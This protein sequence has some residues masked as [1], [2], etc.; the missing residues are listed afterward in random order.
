[1][2][3][4][5]SPIADAGADVELNCTTPV[6]TLDGS[7]S[8]TGANIT[9]QWTGAPNIVNA[10]TLNP[11]VTEPGIYTLIVVDANTGCSSSDEME[12]FADTNYPVISLVI[13]D[14]C[15]GSSFELCPTIVGGSGNF[16][17]EWFYNGIILANTECVTFGEF[18]TNQIGTYDVVLTDAQNG[19]SIIQSISLSATE[20][21]WPGDTDTNKVVNNFDLLNIGLA[22]D[23]TG[24]IRQNATL[25]WTAQTAENWAE[26]TPDN[27][28]YKHIDT[29]GNGTINADDTLAIIQNWGL[30]H[31]LWG[32]DDRNVGTPFYVQSDTFTADVTYA[33]PVILGA[34]D[35]P[36]AEVYG[37]AFTL[38]FD[39]SII[40]SN[41]S[42]NFETSWLGGIDTD[43]IAIQKTTLYT[44]GGRI[45]AAVTRIDGQN[46]TGFGQMGT[47]YIT[48]EDIIFQAPPG[49]DVFDVEKEL[50]FKIENVKMIGFDGQI[51]EVDTEPQPSLSTATNSLFLAHQIQVFPN[52]ATDFLNIYSPFFLMEQV[53]VFNLSGQRIYANFEKNSQL[54]LNTNSWLPST[55]FLKIK[56]Q[57]GVILKKVVIF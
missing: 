41:A 6:A 13:P 38:V 8:A 28:N 29:D 48:I 44:Q 27:V 54:I 15:L 21:V 34:E 7:A 53:E 55:Y 26:M 42:L 10:F 30:I 4:N 31:N 18:T 33:I 49:G 37:I 47:F 11:M 12:V 24:F 3:V 56:T 19:C 50:I 46:M 23:A 1:M 25:D 57:E 14:F 17:Y 51:I 9:Y 5:E 40:A 39:T 2:F 43:M 52:P 16:T 45:D 32:V 35:F 36:A 22:Y 20:C